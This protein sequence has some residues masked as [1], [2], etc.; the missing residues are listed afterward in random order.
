[1]FS[2]YSG[3]YSGEATVISTAALYPSSKRGARQ[4]VLLLPIGCLSFSFLGRFGN[5]DDVDV[6]AISLFIII[7]GVGG[8][9]GISQ[10]CVIKQ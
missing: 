8:F 4:T 2:Y 10:Q 1:M 9:T 3:S 6:L 5:D 7:G